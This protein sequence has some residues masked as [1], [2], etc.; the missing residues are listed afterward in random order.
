[1]LVNQWQ[2]QKKE[3]QKET[4]V[5][6]IQSIGYR[7]PDRNQIGIAASNWNLH[8]DK[9]PLTVALPQ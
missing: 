7:N 1:M 9:T 8:S 5:I 2:R 3:Q 4:Q 6:W